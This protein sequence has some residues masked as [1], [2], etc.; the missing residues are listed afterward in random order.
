MFV[1]LL[2]VAR[3]ATGLSCPHSL[4]ADGPLE[5]HALLA[6]E[7]ALRVDLFLD[8]L[9]LREAVRAPDVLLHGDALLL[10]LGVREVA[11]AVVGGVVVL[12]RT[13]RVGTDVVVL[14]ASEELAFRGLRVER[15]DLGEPIWAGLR[16]PVWKINL[17]RTVS[18][19][20][21]DS[22]RARTGAARRRSSKSR[23]E[24]SSDREAC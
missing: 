13:K 4:V 17:V 22:A 20:G 2:L 21:D 14:R 3:P 6:L 8:G 15:G 19:T 11:G 1:C 12:E 18:T 16:E 7:K 9:E 24:T 5:A 10:A 23:R